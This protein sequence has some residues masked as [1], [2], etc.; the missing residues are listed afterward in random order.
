MI[1]RSK[2][3]FA[4]TDR[5]PVGGLCVPKVGSSR[6]SPWDG[7]S[8]TDDETAARFDSGIQR[9]SREGEKERRREGEKERRREG[10]KERR[11]EGGWWPVFF[12]P[13]R[14]RV[15][16]SVLTRWLRQGTE[17]W[18]IPGVD[19]PQMNADEHR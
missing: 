1:R 5:E 8:T 17:V 6:H 11:R 18:R 3:A 13:S 4:S 12:A 2:A 19:E 10:E 15:R 16:H 7:G 14:L 9:A